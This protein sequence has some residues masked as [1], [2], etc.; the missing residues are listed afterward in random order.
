MIEA[1]PIFQV[2]VPQS[3]SKVC[4]RTPE[5]I[6]GSIALFYFVSII[7]SIKMSAAVK[8]HVYSK[9]FF[10]LCNEIIKSS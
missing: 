1:N 10:E 2:A 4:L 6:F 7:Q 9:Q 5:C 8:V 3:S